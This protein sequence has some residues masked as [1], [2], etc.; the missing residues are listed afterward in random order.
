MNMARDIRKKHS[1]NHDQ[2]YTYMVCVAMKIILQKQ[3]SAG[4]ANLFYYWT[5]LMSLTTSAGFEKNEQLS[6]KVGQHDL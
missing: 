3:M 2:Y 4:N 5:L 1:S 6:F